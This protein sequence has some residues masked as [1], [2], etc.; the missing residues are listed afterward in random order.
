MTV[1]D[2]PLVNH[3]TNTITLQQFFDFVKKSDHEKLDDP[4]TIKPATQKYIRMFKH[5][6]HKKFF[7][8]WNWSAFFFSFYWMVFRKM[9]LMAIGFTVGAL[10]VWSVISF[11][12][13]SLF[14]LAN[15]V[16]HLSYEMQVAGGFILA[17]PTFIIMSVYTSASYNW[18]YLRHVKKCILKNKWNKAG[19]SK[20]ALGATVILIILTRML[21]IYIYD[22]YND[23]K[24]QT[25]LNDTH[26]IDKNESDSTLIQE[27]QNQLSSS[28][29][30]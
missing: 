17:L 26:I 19:V 10:L 1:T 8:S 23:K 18:L 14:H 29:D 16:Y 13:I 25:N 6:D 7:L 24:S 3:D 27:K 4:L 5:H 15:G 11:A 20:K 9:Y 30:L 28:S 21:M 2:T 22:A 12:F